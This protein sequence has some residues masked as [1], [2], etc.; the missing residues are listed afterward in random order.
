MNKSL[1]NFAGIFCVILSS[2]IQT[3]Y[4]Q[5]DNVGIGTTVPQEN[6]ILDISSTEKGL[7]IPRLN[8]LQRLAVAP[9]AGSDGL[10]VYDTDL[11]EFCYWD[12]N[13]AQWVCIAQG[14]SQ[15]PTGPTGAAGTNGLPGPAGPTGPQGP[16][17]A[18][19]A[20]GPTGPAGLNGATGP[21][22]AIGPQGPTGPAGA[23]GPTGPAGPAGANGATGPTGPAGADGATGP[24]GPQGTQGA[25]GPQ[26]PQ[27]A[28]G[29]TGPAAANNT[30]TIDLASQTQL[31]ATPTGTVTYVPLP[32]LT[33]SFTVPAGETWHV[34]CTAFGT[35]LNLGS[36]DDCV[37]QF[38][39][40][41]DGVGTTKLQRAYIGDSSTT[42]TF[43]YGTWSVSYANS[44]GP[45]SYTLDV[46][47]AH[48]GPTG[49]TEIQ[50]AGAPGGFQSHFELLI[51]K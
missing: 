18:D 43:A 12:E 38:E 21:A 33:H 16:A 35:A 29:A 24:Q 23:D 26:G 30:E 46:R 50:L 6:A 48:A 11:D 40:F 17:G 36:F 37:A 15:G 2:L 32:D 4:A 42:L 14:G 27:G 3:G 1:R 34:Y 8:T 41:Q 51:V 25:T 20:T 13:D 19:G 44:F 31:T 9:V 22:G 49:G 7:L 47:G 28:Q 45:G 10:I 39:I 5:N